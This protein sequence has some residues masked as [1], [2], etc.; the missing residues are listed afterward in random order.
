MIVTANG[1]SNGTT[2]GNFWM[3][4]IIRSTCSKND[5]NQKVMGIVR[6]DSSSTADPTSTAW[7]SAAVD[8][9]EDEDSSLLVPYLALAASDSPD[10]EDSFVSPSSHCKR[11]VKSTR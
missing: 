10:V 7:A 4:A 11:Y 3:R 9:C 5:D 2:D 8:D 1:T 6:Y